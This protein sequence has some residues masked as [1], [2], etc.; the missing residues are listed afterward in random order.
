M[1]VSNELAEG[2][3][4]PNFSHSPSSVIINTQLPV[5]KQVAHDMRSFGT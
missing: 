3:G 1:C 4:L 2:S 5:K